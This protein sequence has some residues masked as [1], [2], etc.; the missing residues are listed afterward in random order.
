M[1]WVVMHSRSQQP[2]L[3]P[4]AGPAN[5]HTQHSKSQA[6]PASQS[7]ALASLCQGRGCYVVAAAICAM[8]S[9]P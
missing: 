5:K 6:Y 9:S 4:V 2:V 8:P 1:I 3:R 7:Q